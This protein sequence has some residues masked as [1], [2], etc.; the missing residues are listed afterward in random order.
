[1]NTIND[2]MIN[3]LVY[4]ILVNHFY[5]NTYQ[6]RQKNQLLISNISIYRMISM[7]THLMNTQTMTS[8]FT[9]NQT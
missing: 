2:K 5:R 6:V 9:T 3:E 1:M 8:V 4:H 7:N